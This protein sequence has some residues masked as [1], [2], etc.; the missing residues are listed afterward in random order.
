M[1]Q[2]TR[3]YF[4]QTE[5]AGVWDR[6]EKGDPLNA[7]A[8]GLDRSH[9]TVQGALARTGGIDSSSTPLAPPASHSRQSGLLR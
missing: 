5:L 8:R 2:R 3:R 9:S 6:W 4:S 7:I 1:K